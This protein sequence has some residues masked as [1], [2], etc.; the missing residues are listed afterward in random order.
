MPKINTYAVAT[1]A[2]DDELVGTDVSDTG[3]DANGETAQ[4]TVQSLR[5][6]MVKGVGQCYLEFTSTTVLTLKQKNGRFIQIAG[7][8]HEIPAAGT[9]LGTG[10]LSTYTLYYIYAY[11]NSGTLTLEASTTAWTVST[12]AGNEGMPIKTGDNTRTFVGMTYTD[13][14]LAFNADWHASYWNPIRRTVTFNETSQ[15]S[16]TSTSWAALGTSLYF[17]Y[18]TGHPHPRSVITTPVLGSA[19]GVY[20]YV[21]GYL[22]GSSAITIGVN[23]GATFGHVTAGGVF[24]PSQGLPY[25]QPWGVVSA[26]TGYYGVSGA[27]YLKSEVEF[28]G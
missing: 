21:A 12:T 26:G 25:V 22:N 23:Q 11:D 19:A 5:D 17:P 7:E 18:I 10:G 16:T 20:V 9:T 13:S 3:N 14:P 2:I 4:F 15:L 8:L 28:W 27:L 6:L 24:L 1:P